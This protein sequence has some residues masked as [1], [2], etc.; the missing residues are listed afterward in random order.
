MGAKQ[1]GSNS[2]YATFETKNGRIVTIRLANHNA[3]VSTFDN[4]SESNDYL[5]T[6][7]DG[8]SNKIYRVKTTMH[9][10]YEKGRSPHDYRVT[11]VELLISGSPTNNALSNSTKADTSNWYPLAKLLQNVEKSYDFGKNC[12]KRAKKL[13]EIF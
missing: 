10:H 11:K 13:K 3:K 2:Q 7:I 5:C 4:R 8:N 6:D 1:E 12:L 9:E